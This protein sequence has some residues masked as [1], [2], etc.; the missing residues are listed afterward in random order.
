[1]YNSSRRKLIH[2]FLLISLTLVPLLTMSSVRK[3][4]YD[5]NL[6]IT[7]I[8]KGD[9]PFKVGNFLGDYGSNNIYLENDNGLYLEGKINGYFPS[10]TSKFGVLLQ[11]T[12]YVH[13][14]NSKMNSDE[15]IDVIVMFDKNSSQFSR[16]KIA[17]DFGWTNLILKEFKIIPAYVIRLPIKELI[18]KSELLIGN[19]S[20]LKIFSDATVNIRDFTQNDITSTS[21]WE[22]NWW[23]KAIGA[24]N[25]EFNGSNVNI[26]ILDTGISY[27]HKDLKLKSPEN[28][29]LSFVTDEETPKD[30]NGHGTH[31]AG[32][33]AGK[34]EFL[35]GKYRGV[36][37]EARLFNLK[38]ANMSGSIESSD[39]ISA[40]EWATHN[41]ID[42][43][44]MSFGSAYPEVYNPQTAA[45][46][47]ANKLGIVTVASAGNSGPLFYTGGNP[48]AGVSV[49]SVGAIG[50]NKNLAEFSSI[51]PSYM[52]HVM[53][54]ILAPGVNIISTEERG[55]L[56]SNLK[57]YT[58]SYVS[59]SG[60]YSNY[61]P[62]SG[63]SMSSPMVAGAIALILQAFPGLTPEAVRI[64]LYNGA[65]IPNID[66]KSK[67]GFG[68]GIINV[69]ASIEWLNSQPNRYELVEAFPKKLPISPFDLIKY[70]GDQQNI[71]ISIFSSSTTPK[72]VNIILPEIDGLEITIDKNQLFFSNHSVK[73][74]EIGLK[75]SEN[76]SM[77]FKNSTIL[78]KD[79]ISDEILSEIEI[80]INVKYPK[81]RVFFDSF[82]GLN[83]FLP[84][85]PMGYK[86]IDI[87][88]SMKFLHEIG[89]KLDYKMDN[90]VYG[91][92]SSTDGEILT[93]DKI[94]TAD[95]VVL[96]TPIL[97]YTD[98]EIDVLGDFVDQGGSILL[99]GT[100]Y[101]TLSINS[102]N[103]LLNHLNTGIEINK[104]NIFEYTD[105]G[106]GLLLEDKIVSGDQ[107]N[108]SSSI[109]EEGD[110]FPFWFGPTL[111]L[112]KTKNAY[113]LATLDDKTIVAG[114]DGE[115]QGKGNIVVWSD[116]HWLRNDL[117]NENSANLTQ[118]SIL[119]NLFQFLNTRDSN[120]LIIGANFNTTKTSDLQIRA[121]FSVLNISSNSNV[122]NL[123]PGVEMNVTIISPGGSEQRVI[124]NNSLGNGI[125]YNSS[126]TLE[127]S[128]YRPYI[129][130][131]EILTPSGIMERKFS[132]FRINSSE[133]IIINNPR[134]LND[135][136]N[137][138]IG[139][140]NVITYTTPRDYNDLNATLIGSLTPTNIYN[141]KP[142]KS[143][144]L[145]L[146]KTNQ[147]EYQSEFIIT[148]G[149]TSGNF[150]FYAVA[151]NTLPNSH[152]FNFKSYRSFFTII[153]NLPVINEQSSRFNGQIFE[154]TNTNESYYVNE[155]SSNNPLSIIMYA[156]EL[157]SYE[158]P[159]E[160]LSV[161][162]IYLAAASSENVTTLIFPSEIPVCNFSRA[163]SAFS[164]SF[165][166]PNLLEFESISDTVE[167]SQ[168]SSQNYISVLY[169][170]LRDLDGGSVDYIFL[171][172]VNIY[173]GFGSFVDYIPVIILLV[174][175]IGVV[176]ILYSRSGRSSN[177]N[178]NYN[179]GNDIYP[180]ID[181]DF[182]S[183][184]EIQRDFC[185]NCGKRIEPWRTQ[186]PYCGNQL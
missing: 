28:V 61:I 19:D 35:S 27:S 44:S 75:I 119:S 69:S 163:G 109:F 41:N 90:W 111:N 16:I 157:V 92:E 178:S 98:Y 74:V 167:I 93:P 158:D 125:Y 29:N 182:I 162:A 146:L 101:E 97:P 78:L 81:G 53:P 36:A 132:L 184:S 94:M 143:Y 5:S 47:E 133:E 86:Q 15:K 171:L 139:E 134:F 24:D 85:W 107:L 106:I 118:R 102:I 65:Y 33:A 18:E 116:Y 51:G 66:S 23:L 9:L 154:D 87:Y 17:R 73:F 54:D 129:V 117:F 7:A 180:N 100:K 2:G 20:I 160:N 175:I 156:S 77:G 10:L 40:I 3:N 122:S 181:Y 91:Y 62:L 173:S 110:E 32:I 126:I 52:A 155:V 58:N 112:D 30:Y 63:T 186:C 151:N 37:P 131:V 14:I 170:T 38:V 89:Y 123:I 56:L 168:Q 57:R 147:Y 130:K 144:E 145:S 113:T 83:D 45:L 165:D 34:S 138:S 176:W 127:S 22:D 159:I 88:E 31:V 128:D 150:V 166:I 50:R 82:H 79:A 13:K 26:A 42:I 136:I 185:M 70:P 164:C 1:M 142:S 71:N 174:M 114:Y 140:S 137:R 64:A 103:K 4:L 179:Q 141:V 80:I 43:I 108:L 99:L 124:L 95:I 183:Q 25:I 46:T 76:A 153:N 169:V 67:S 177:K 135:T 84:E 104:E 121:D 96:Q 149:E 12:I 11:E 115:F 59:G 60:Y 172:F 68:A 105:L 39:V 72:N 120:N 148:G 161:V 8:N 55:S 48:A 49:I 152:Y 21:S 6:S